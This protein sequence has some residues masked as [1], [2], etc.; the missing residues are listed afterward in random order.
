MDDNNN[1]F[2]K[3][4]NSAEEV[5]VPE[6]LSPENILLKLRE[7]ADAE[8]KQEGEKQ[9]GQ[10]P[11]EQKGQK[12]K[13]Q[14]SKEQKQEDKKP[15]RR[16]RWAYRYGSW[17]A[18]AVIA[19]LGTA[20][21]SSA[22]RKIKGDEKDYGNLPAAEAEL[23]YEADDIANVADEAAETDTKDAADITE[24]V[25]PAKAVSASSYHEI[26]TILQ[27]YQ[28]HQYLDYG[29]IDEEYEGDFPAS[30]EIAID[31]D[32]VYD[33][34][35][36]QSSDLNMKSISS[37][38]AAAGADFS[39]TNTRT[40]GIG[41]ADLVKTDGAFIYALDSKGTIRIVDIQKQEVVSEFLADWQNG[42]R[43]E[44]YVEGNLLQ[45][46][47]NAEEYQ[48]YRNT[49]E[50]SVHSSYSSL[51]QQTKVITYDISDRANPVQKGVYTQDG[52]YLTSRRKDGYLYLFTSYY[53]MYELEEELQ[54]TYI[55][56]A[57]GKLV[58]CEDIY[59]PCTGELSYDGSG[60]L[61]AGSVAD[62]QTETAVDQMCVLGGSGMFY[63]SNQN[64]YTASPYWD[65]NQRKTDLLRFGYQDGIFSEG[66]V[67]KVPGVI[68]DSFC[69]DEYD[70]M[71]RLVSSV[72]AYWSGID[73]LD[74]MNIFHRSN[75]LYVMNMDLEI[76]GRIV[77]I[78]RNEEIKSA[79]FLGDQAYFVTYEN[80]DPLFSA[81]LSDPENPQLLGELKLTGFSEYLHP[82]GEGL[83]LG[84]GWE[85]DPES[86]A[87]HGI[88]CSMFDTSDPG[89]V[90]ELE[91]LV[92]SDADFSDAM[93][94]YKAI[95]INPERNLFGFAYGGYDNDYNS[96]YYYG[97]FTYGEEGLQSLAYIPI[98]GSGENSWDVYGGYAG[99]R[100]MYVKDT[101]YLVND[102]GIFGYAMDRNFEK[103]SEILWDTF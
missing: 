85:T 30:E 68:K 27:E 62:G 49:K 52:S 45:I 76:I 10:K 63:V 38:K 51:E 75:R 5:N 41:E 44:M 66:A 78:A 87:F 89:E 31:E 98:P 100:G 39:E 47:Q 60:F 56:E 82:Y 21:A 102:Y 58:L 18:I 9:E 26:Y 6:S 80:T 93:Y 33:V 65:G 3:I 71:L 99:L 84:I 94:N 50:T 23:V 24:A 101:F 77:G 29:C 83:L 73:W 95:L 55:P 13:E 12:S 11:E 48:T 36:D 2:Q 46:I 17:A 14:K 97:V 16:F 43:I 79:R 53:P 42:Q 19:L 86:G 72:D 25:E 7:Q 81:D 22:Y 32:I 69:M 88:K 103:T 61:V 74:D 35:E 15:I 91:R 92:I 57:G 70:G 20:S 90:M 96:K 8:Q 40:A 54:E 34:M 67:G 37:S 1:L 28:S 64:I 59:Y 4:K